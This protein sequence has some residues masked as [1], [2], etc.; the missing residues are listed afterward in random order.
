MPESVGHLKIIHLGKY[1]P[2]APG[3]IESHVQTLANFQAKLGHKVSVLCVNHKDKNG[4]DVTH[5]R[6]KKTQ[7]SL[8]RDSEVCLQRV[9]R[10]FGINRFEFCPSLPKKL[11]EVSADADIVHLHAPNPL[12]IT[13]WWLAGSRN[14]PLIVTHHS[15]VIK[16]RFLKIF[17][18][19]IEKAV[20]RRACKI[21]SDSPNY[22]EGSDVLQGFSEK[23]ETLPLGVDLEPYIKP[24]D[25]V[26]KQASA[27][28]KENDGIL[29]LM[30]GRMTYY[31]GYHI[32]IEALSKVEGKLV[33]VGNGPLEPDL[34]AQ[35]ERLGVNDRIIWMSSVSQEYLAALYASATA[36]WF[37]S[38]ARSEGF[39]LVQ[40]EAMASGCPVINTAIQASGVSWVSRDGESGL[41]VTPGDPTEFAKKAKLLSENPKLI[42]RLSEGARKRAS[43]LFDAVAMAHKSISLY[44]AAITKMCNSARK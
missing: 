39:G 38:I 9:G 25:C 36:L 5:S 8:E 22:I 26:L 4:K 3:G 24:K 21:L 1:Y 12:M 20:Y 32:A 27:I 40:V 6:W 35:A 19:P 44:Q 7:N 2:P 13:A 17:V 18:S 16:Q 30:V 15:D 11:A 41:T 37:P 10:W 31:K 28:K 34:K 29:W 23:V 14:V 43:L 42:Q 33:I